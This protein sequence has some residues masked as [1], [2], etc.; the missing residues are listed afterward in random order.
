MI[1]PIMLNSVPFKADKIHKDAE[2]EYIDPLMKWPLRGAAFTNEIGEALRPIIGNY[3]TLTWAPALLYIG[4]DIYDK[5]KNDQTEFSPDSRRC[6]KQACFQGLASI[7]LPI[8]AVKGG[9][10]LFSLFGLMTKDRLTHNSKE[11]ILKLA[12]NFVANGNMRAYENNDDECIKKFMDI[13][14]NNLDY[15][16]YENLK[17]KSI[18]KFIHETL[19]INTKD[20]TKK[21]SKNLII[22]MIRTRK[23]LLNPTDTYKENYLYKDFQKALKKGETQSVAV[24]SVLHDFLNSKTVKGRS[25]KTIGGFLALGLAIKPID[26]FVEHY[27][28]GRVIGPGIDNIK[29]PEK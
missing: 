3:A 24:K 4:A 27:V 9:Q 2:G 19:K 26:Y 13:V 28:I 23:F 6:L 15:K 18:N 12:K 29:R 25:I 11:H 14:E 17:P 1:K 21:Y 20:N 22:K 8:I 7:L 16:K 10:N 5:Y